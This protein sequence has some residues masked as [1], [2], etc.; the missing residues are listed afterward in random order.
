MQNYISQFSQTLIDFAE[1]HQMVDDIKFVTSASELDNMVF[2]RKTMLVM[3]LSA[4]IDNENGR[5]V[6]EVNYAIGLIDKATNGRYGQSAVVEESLFVLS[7]LQH[8]LQQQNYSAV[9][10]EVD[11]QTD[12]DVSGELVALL[13]DVTAQ[14]GRSV[15]DIINF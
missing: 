9:F 12:W 8:H 2:D 10:G 7:Q 15:D 4:D 14:F 6:Y 1:G 5:P 3:M 11:I 13:A